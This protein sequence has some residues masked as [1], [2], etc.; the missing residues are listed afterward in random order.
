MKAKEFNVI[1]IRKDGEVQN[2]TV[3]FGTMR[4]NSTWFAKN[5]KGVS[6]K[7]VKNKKGILSYGTGFS[8]HTISDE[9]IINCISDDLN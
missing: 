2:V 9:N 1:G 8:K 5:D 4:G 3:Y 6:C 7:I